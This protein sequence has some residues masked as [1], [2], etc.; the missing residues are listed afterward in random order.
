MSCQN[1]TAQA[2]DQ[3]RRQ[4]RPI[5]LVDVRQPEEYAVVHAEGARLVPLDQLDSK[6]ILSGRS[7][8]AGEPIYLICRSGGRSLAACQRLQGSGINN[9]VNVEGGTIAWERAGLPVIRSTTSTSRGPWL[10][11]IGLLLVLAGFVLGWTLNPWF[12]LMSVVAWF[13]LIVAGGGTCPLGTC[14]LPA[15]PRQRTL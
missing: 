5:D 7:T 3:L 14:A 12:S 8:G 4:G 6:S 15:Q 10:R 2:L 11:R 1:I 9:V 13:G